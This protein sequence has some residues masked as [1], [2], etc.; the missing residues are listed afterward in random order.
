MNVPVLPQPV[1][2]SDPSR[3][4]EW[5]FVFSIVVGLDQKPGGFIQSVHRVDSGWVSLDHS[6]LVGFN[7]ADNEVDWSVYFL[8]LELF[9]S[10][11]VSYFVF[12]NFS[13]KPD[14][15][16]SIIQDDSAHHI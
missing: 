4:M 5:I 8:G 1:L 15:R 7:T 14:I 16:N 9:E 3:V 6:S 12:K 13:N 10:V 11:L 2:H